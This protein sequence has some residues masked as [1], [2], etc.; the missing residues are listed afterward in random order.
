MEEDKFVGKLHFSFTDEF[1]T[2]TIDKEYHERPEDFAT[3][4]WLVEEFKH[5]LKGMGFLESQTD[6]IV[7]LEEGENVVDGYGHVLVECN[8]GK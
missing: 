2:T 4:Y 5:I 3:I 7:Y 6:R 1:E 8:I